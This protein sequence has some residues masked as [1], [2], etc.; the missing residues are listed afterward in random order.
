MSVKS[1]SSPTIWLW[2]LSDPIVGLPEITPETF[3]VPT[4]TRVFSIDPLHDGQRDSQQDS[5]ES[6]FSPWARAWQSV[7][8]GA[9]WTCLVWDKRERRRKER[10]E[11]GKGRESPLI[12]GFLL[13]FCFFF[14]FFFIFYVYIYI[15]LQ[16]HPLLFNF[17]WP[18]LKFQFLHVYSSA[19]WFHVHY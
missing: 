1:S 10:E 2:D 12:G 5:F 4:A 19:W 15:Y 13:F 11:E 7:A 17:I 16:S 3:G 9:W 18:L 14:L 6:S 8:S